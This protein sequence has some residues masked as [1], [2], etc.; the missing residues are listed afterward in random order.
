MAAKPRAVLII[1]IVAVAIAAFASISRYNYLKGQEAKMKEA[2]AIE[3]IVVAREEISAGTSLDTNRVKVVDWPRASMPQ[4][5]FSVPE[6]VTGRMALDRF[7]PGEPIIETKLVPGEA[8]T[9]VLTY[10]V[11]QGHRAMTVAVDQVAGVA[12]FITPGNMVDMVL[13]T[14]PVGA[15]QPVGKIV[16][17]NVPV[18]A[19]GQIIEQQKDGK[20]VVVPTVTVDVTP[21]D[22]EKLA[23]ASNQGRL[24]LVLRRAGDKE[25]A[26]TT[27]ATV[28][29]VLS[30]VTSKAEPEKTK[31][32]V[33]KKP[34]AKEEPK[35][36]VKTDKPETIAVEVWRSTA[37][38]VETFKGE[39]KEK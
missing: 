27:G 37:K 25:I 26:R 15:Q 13:T 1:G 5:S 34:V 12:G 17:Q 7:M 24:Q 36:A 29:K 30:G 8:Q 22:A 28:T 39:S 21:E 32:K 33:A 23:I 4:G 9:G 16:L 20:P 14:T 18:L 35:A 10:K 6:M 2:G 19:I 31:G 11:P 3:K 38:T